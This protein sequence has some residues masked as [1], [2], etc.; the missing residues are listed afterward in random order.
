[1][2]NATL[3]GGIG[4]GAIG[5]LKSVTPC[6]ALVVGLL[7]GALSTYG[8]ANVQPKLL[9]K[10]GLH[11]TC[12]VHNLHGMPAILSGAASALFVA[13][14]PKSQVYEHAAAS[15]GWR[16]LYQVFGTLLTLA[17]SL[18]AGVV[19]G[20]I[21]VKLVPADTGYVS[22][23]DSVAWD[24][25]LDYEAG[26]DAAMDGSTHQLMDGSKSKKAAVKVADTELQT[27]T[28]TNKTV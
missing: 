4:I 28:P 5:R 8:Y 19:V 15:P 26:F 9:A 25:G 18:L 12:A 7:S 11:D 10:Y 6:G 2:Q 1:M 20:K 17:V 23:H 21:A 3:A 22:F 13:L 27:A 24:V 14:A 16:A